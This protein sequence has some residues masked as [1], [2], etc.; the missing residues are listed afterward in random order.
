MGGVGNG[1]VGQAECDPPRAHVGGAGP[2]TYHTPNS[3]WVDQPSQHGHVGGTSEHIEDIALEPNDFGYSENEMGSDSEEEGDAED[4]RFS[5]RPETWSKLY[6]SYDPVPMPFTGDNSGLTE[7]YESIP[8]YVELF[9][10]FWSHETL[11]RINRYAGSLDEN[12]VPRGRGGWYP[13]TEK[14]LKVFMAVILYMGMKKLPNMKAYWAKSEEFFYCNVIAGLFTRKRFL[15]LLRCLHV[16]DPGTYVEDRSSPEFDKMHQT[17]WLINEMKASCKREW[18]L[19]Q[20]VTV[21]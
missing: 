7:Q 2:S 21:D 15:A 3:P 18:H 20:H 11:R 19:G 8:S 12:R 4:I 6:A 16:T 5:Y 17:R 14:E 10:K 1:G 9:R 13:I